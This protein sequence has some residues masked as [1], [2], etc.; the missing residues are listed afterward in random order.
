[1]GAH[2]YSPGDFVQRVSPVRSRT[3]ATAELDDDA[4]FDV[5]FVIGHRGNT[6]PKRSGVA[7]SFC[8]R[9]PRLTPIPGLPFAYPLVSFYIKE[10]HTEPTANEVFEVL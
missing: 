7:L 6:V 3:Q 10:V 5:E 2:V 9:P 1:M 4:F 8:D